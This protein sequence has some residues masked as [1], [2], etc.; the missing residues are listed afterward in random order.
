MTQQFLWQNI[1]P[2]MQIDNTSLTDSSRT[3]YDML[4]QVNIY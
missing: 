3:V 1:Q 2:V 4:I